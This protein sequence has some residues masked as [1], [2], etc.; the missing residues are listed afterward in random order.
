VVVN[1]NEDGNSEIVEINEGDSVEDMLR[2]VHL[3]AEEFRLA[4]AQ[5]ANSKLPE[6]ERSEVLA[7]LDAGLKGY[8]YLEDI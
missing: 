5:L 3:D 6:H 1:V 8:T 2:Y 7:E 4:F